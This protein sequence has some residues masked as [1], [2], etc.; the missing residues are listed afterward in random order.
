[1]YK[2][3]DPLTNPSLYLPRTSA[4]VDTGQR[5]YCRLV[6][7]Y[8]T[9]YSA[10]IY[11]T[12]EGVLSAKFYISVIMHTATS[13]CITT[14]EAVRLIVDGLWFWMPLDMAVHGNTLQ[15]EVKIEFLPSWSNGNT[16]WEIKLIYQ[17]CYSQSITQSVKD[18]GSS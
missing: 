5:I 9:W 13:S 7:P 3:E 11:K 16:G 18:K 17:T 8:Q 14:M 10:I 4:S 12:L 2:Y 15:L 6:G 1:M